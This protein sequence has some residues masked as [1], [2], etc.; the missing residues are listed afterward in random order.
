VRFIYHGLSVSPPKK[1]ARQGKPKMPLYGRYFLRT[2][3]T[4]KASIRFRD[5]TI[6]HLNQDTD[7]VLHDPH[8]TVVKRG[9]V[10]QIDVRPGTN[11]RV[12]TATAVAAAVGTSLDVRVQGRKSTIIVV[13]GKVIV[14]NKK[15]KVVVRPNHETVVVPGKPPSKPAAVD[16]QAATAWAQPLSGATWDTMGGPDSLGS[17]QRVAVDSDG[18]I[19]VTDNK[20]ERVIKLSPKGAQ[21]A[22]WGSPGQGNEQFGSPVGIAVDSQNNVYVVDEGYSRIEKFTSSGQFLAA[23]GGTGFDPGSFDGPVDVAVDSQGNMYVADTALCRVQK[24]SPNGQSLAVWGELGKCDNASGHF[25]LP[26]GVAVDPSGNVYVADT[27]NN[28]I[29]KLSA[30]GQVLAIWGGE[31]GSKPGQFYGPTDI[32]LDT[33]GNLYVADPGNYRLQKL[34]PDGK[35]LMTWGNVLT[36]SPETFLNAYGVATDRQGNLF[37]VDTGYLR[38][39]TGGAR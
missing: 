37:V 7:A 4:E 36:N 24:L 25:S 13:E 5:G 20:N 28:R 14:T 34:S 11:H 38:R 22:T 26:S 3:H 9:E 27:I 39:L 21:L 16:A 32:A 8:V 35:P 18:N 10:N 33:H 15:G 29:V 31:R 30:S 17:P 2:K 6:L 23:F 12:Q 1:K 19:Y